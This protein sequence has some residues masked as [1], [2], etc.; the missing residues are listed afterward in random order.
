MLSIVLSAIPATIEYKA[1]LVITVQ[2]IS[3]VKPVY[4]FEKERVAGVPVNEILCS[5][6]K[7]ARSIGV[8]IPYGTNASDIPNQGTPVIGGLI[9]LEYEG[10]SHVAVIQEFTDKG[11]KVKESNFQPCLKTE[12]VISY[13]DIFIRGFHSGVFQ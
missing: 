10:Y 6:V 8:K 4:A 3:F 12:R 1:P 9:L 5:C 7:Y 11:F 13:E 2:E